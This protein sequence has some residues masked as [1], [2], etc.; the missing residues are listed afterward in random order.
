MRAEPKHWSAAIRSPDGLPILN[1]VLRRRAAEQPER[2]GYT[3]LADGETESEHL[4]YGELE[5]RARAVAVA[6]REQAAPGDRAVLLFPPGLDFVAGFFGCLYA[7]VVAVPLVPPSFRKGASRLRAVLEDCSPRVVLTTSTL[8]GRAGAEEWREVSWLALDEIADGA[9]AAW[10]DPGAGPETV[11]FLQYT[12]GSTGEP[13]GVVVTH[14]NLA[15]NEEA[16]RTTFGQ[17]E[18]S[19]IV[20]WLPLY[21]DMGLIGNVLQ[22]LWVGAPCTL[23]A[24]VS[25]LQRPRRW[26][27]AISRYRATTSGGPNFA[28][29]LCVRKVPPAEREGLDL[30]CWDV[31]FNGAEPVRAATLERFAEAFSGA[32]FSRRAFSPC[33]GLA[34]ATLLVSG[35]SHGNEHRTLTL[36]AGALGRH[37]IA[38]PGG[39]EAEVVL[40]GS[41]APAA[42]QDALVVDPETRRA[43]APDR[44]GEIW[45]RGPSVARGYWGREGVSEETFAAHLASG[46]G[47]FLRTGDLGFLADGELFVTGRLKDLIILRGRNL[48]PHDIETTV[49]GCHSSLR[50]GCAAAFSRDEDGEERLVVVQELAPRTREID[51]AAAEEVAEAVRRAVADDHEAQ[52]HELVL[53]RAGALPKTTSGKIRRRACRE[54]LLAG[55]LPVLARSRLDTGAAD[56]TRRTAA[57]TGPDPATLRA[58]APAERTAVLAAWLESTCARILGVDV[59]PGRPLPA[60]GLDSLAAI[61][62]GHEIETA[63]GAAPSLSDL[64]A[65]ATVAGLAADLERRVGRP[66]PIAMAAGSEAEEPEA[67]DHPPSC[68]QESLWFLERLAP[69]SGAYHLTG[70]ARI[71][72]P[73]DRGAFERALRRLSVRHAVLRTVLTVDGDRLVQR[74]LPELAPEVTWEEAP[75]ASETAARERLAEIQIGRAHV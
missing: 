5:T 12:S 53:I 47:P 49:D 4:T 57:A 71:A 41:G 67:G 55:E 39:G 44:V 23:M 7:G 69:G 30:S 58:L 14:G 60:L 16:I 32:G 25:F 35:T 29:D 36:D 26:L 73:F 43:T 2:V 64:L 28:Y 19:R 50:P 61:E 46:E 38:G 48:Y 66:A 9:E 33:Y 31:A 72:P 70:A 65:G 42:D 27:E 56:V 40:T 59:D 8:A 22:P 13:N 51:P 18:G 68:G 10:V 21:H 37:E 54:L 17:S 6:L 34:E 74:V 3:F 24:P 11:A 75:E 52:V 45:V 20:G 62:L 63:V 1:D 15:Y